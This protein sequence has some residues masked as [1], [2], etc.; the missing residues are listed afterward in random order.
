MYFWLIFFF[1][2]QKALKRFQ[3]DFWVQNHLLNLF[4]RV[5]YSQSLFCSQ[6]AGMKLISFYYLCL[7]LLLNCI[8]A[9]Y[10]KTGENEFKRGTERKRKKWLLTTTL[11]ILF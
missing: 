6:K 1:E 4:S 8:C 11:V 3:I 7:K 5:V 9:I 2:C 10:I